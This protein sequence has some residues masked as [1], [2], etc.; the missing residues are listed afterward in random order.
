MQDKQAGKKA[1][2]LWHIK[3]RII[4]TV[5]LILTVVVLVIVTVN[6][7]NTVSQLNQNGRDLMLGEAGNNA[8]LINEWLKKQGTSVELMK[9][10][11]EKSNYKDTA[12]IENYLEECLGKNSAALMYY[13]CYDYDGGVF[14]ADHS[15]LDLDPTTRGWWKDAQSAGKL[16]YTDPYQD[17]A[18][19]SM[20]VSVC[21]PYTCEG[22][23]CAILADISLDELVATVE[24]IS[25]SD[26]VQSFLLAAD[27]SV[28]T[29]PNKDF[30]PKE[31]GNT[32]LS[33]KV[34]IDTNSTEA[35]TI[36]DYDGEKKIVAVAG[37]EETGWKLGVSESSS[38]V[39]NAVLHDII[40]N[41]AIALVVIL[42]SIFLL[43]VVTKRQLAQLNRMR[44]FIKD[45][46]IGRENVK[47]MS[48]ERVEIGYL[49]DE[50]ENRFLATIR[51]TA[52]ESGVIYAD[53]EETKELIDSVSEGIESIN[54]AMLQTSA[55]TESQTDS[56]GS[57]YT[58]SGEVAASVDSLAAETQGMAGKATEI[59]TK[60]EQTIPEIGRAHV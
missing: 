33:E 26:D 31:E 46:V 5:L 25:D 48:S 38:V 19:G 49:I 35:Q 1:G 21:S 20:I 51:E 11:L 40:W 56:I 7:I 47:L 22:H 24:G 34:D 50:L 12:S 41:V 53:M 27:G 13:V 17:F 60:I 16:I 43:L 57:I 15:K 2:I 45:R 54:S 4:A 9:V 39:G 42:I 28:I 29:H 59:I 30:L 37:I 18:T 58:M 3:D 8:E 44:L 14:P 36:N 23:T 6:S 32:I 52:D 55:S 10:T